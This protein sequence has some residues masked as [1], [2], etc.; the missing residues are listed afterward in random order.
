MRQ[1]EIELRQ[2]GSEEMESTAHILPRMLGEIFLLSGFLWFGFSALTSVGHRVALMVFGV[3]IVCFLQLGSLKK[4]WEIYV[5]PAIALLCV[6][7][8]IIRRKDVVQGLISFSNQMIE[9]WNRTFDDCLP[10][11]SVSGNTEGNVFFFL[12]L[13][14]LVAA[15]WID[16]MTSRK[17]I[18]ASTVTVVVIMVAS[19]LFNLSTA[20]ASII[21][22]LAGWLSVLMISSADAGFFRRFCI[23][24]VPVCV[25]VFAGGLL[26]NTLFA[27]T[28]SSFRQN[29]SAKIT[30]WRYGKD[31]LPK[32]DLSKESNLHEGEEERL[33]VQTEDNGALYLKGYV[34]A[35]YNGKS[36]KSLKKANYSGENA[37]ILEW[38]QEQ[39]L[40]VQ[41]QYSNYMDARDGEYLSE[42]SVNKVVVENKG[43]SRRYAYAPTTVQRIDNGNCEAQMDWQFVST[44]FR[45]DSYFSYMCENMVLL[46]EEMAVTPYVNETYATAAGVYRDFVYDNYLSIDDEMKALMNKVFY[47]DDTWS[48]VNLSVSKVTSRIRAVLEAKEEYADAPEKTESDDRIRQFLLEN[49]TGNAIS[50]ASAAVM[51]FRAKNI[52]ARYVE[53]YYLPE[54]SEEE[55]LQG[56]RTV[57]LTTKHAHVWVEVYRDLIGWVPIEV[58]PGYYSTYRS[59][60]QVI[61]IPIGEEGEDGVEGILQPAEEEYADAGETV[62]WWTGAGAGQKAAILA[63]GVVAFAA[64]L[65]IILEVQRNVRRRMRREKRKKVSMNDHVRLLFK[66]MMLYLN[67]CHVPGTDSE[68]EFRGEG[69]EKQ[70]SSISAEEYNHMITQMQRVLFGGH[71]LTSEELQELDEFTERLSGAAAGKCGNF[72]RRLVCRYR[73]AI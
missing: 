36:W 43:A 18:V 27:P 40:T 10:Y 29:I 72:W 59:G 32:G 50:Y 54:A 42:N 71:G 44:G 52:P 57:T 66:Q 61:P 23:I 13:A 21:F 35:E 53:G 30:D 45:G 20:V 51:A 24:T 70:C 22:L 49:H 28:V 64:V 1:K 69:L 3:F 41:R 7:L 38:L 37:G 2:T 33:Q 62:T 65:L 8:G 63:A 55:R 58:T 4:E 11:L 60:R 56:E 16:L 39:G 67:I 26:A 5:Y 68:P 31:S 19:S 25:F 6:M 73:Y 48:D 9:C 14:T 15:V 47:G 34:G 17:W 12:L 46:G